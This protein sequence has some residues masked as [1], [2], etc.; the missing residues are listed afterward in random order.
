MTK[1]RAIVILNELDERI[2]VDGVREHWA[3]LDRDDDPLF[4]C[5]LTWGE[6]REMA[7]HAKDALR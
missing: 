5:E 6:I 7:R 1:E 3:L 4:E 2:E